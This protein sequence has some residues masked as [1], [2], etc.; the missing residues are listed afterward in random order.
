MSNA[1]SPAARP[2]GKFSIGA[3]VAIA[4]LAAAG[5]LV[6]VNVAAA[7]KSVRRDVSSASSYGLSDR[8]KSILSDF[9]GD[10]YISTLYMPAEDDEKQRSYI[11]RVQDYCEELQRFDPRVKVTYVTSPMQREKLV[12]RISSTFGGEAGK[13]KEAI[14][15]FNKLQTELKADF[16]QRLEEGRKLMDE[17]KWLGDFPIFA[18]IV[19]TLKQD[20]ES[21]Q[22]AADEIKELTP[23]GGIPKYGEATTKAKTAVADI[24]THLTTIAKRLAELAVLADETTKADS[25]RIAMLRDVAAQ[26]RSLVGTLRDTVGE[27]GSQVKDIPAALKAFADKGSE[28]GTALDGLVSRVDQFGKAFPMVRQ[29]PSWSAQVQMGPLVT[30]LEVAEVNAGER[31]GNVQLARLAIQPETVPI[32]NAIG[33]V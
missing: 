28:V 20:K 19:N 9:K 15:A 29:H 16:D 25:K 30:R 11:S 24:K 14:E 32:E 5:I 8:T 6:I 1:A 26:A 13:H 3:N 18:S 23:V 4:I 12:T 22:K 31:L 7:M 17:D 21:L 10:I 2:A 33:R 27:E